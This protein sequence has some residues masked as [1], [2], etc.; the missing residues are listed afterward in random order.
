MECYI[1]IS[2]FLFSFFFNFGFLSLVFC[3]YM[4]IFIIVI[5]SG[6]ID[7]FIIIKCPSSSLL[8]VYIVYLFLSFYFQSMCNYS[9]RQ[10]IVGSCFIFK[11]SLTNSAFWLNYLVH[12][13]LLWV[14]LDFH[15]L[16]CFH[17]LQVF[18]VR[19]FILYYLLFHYMNIA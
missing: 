11:P 10:Y 12:L 15:L 1:S 19:L 16:Y 3:C 18:F 9:C 5:S 17:M 7:S 4:H 14:Q 13:L 8:V 2:I 6:W